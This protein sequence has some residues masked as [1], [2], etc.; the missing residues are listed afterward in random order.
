MAKEN[1]EGSKE[2][3]NPWAKDLG[4]LGTCWHTQVP[5]YQFPGGCFEW[6]AS[7]SSSVPAADSPTDIDASPPPSR[8]STQSDAPVG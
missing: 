2:I 3:V 7:E 8:V 1:S 6:Q 5:H 4:P